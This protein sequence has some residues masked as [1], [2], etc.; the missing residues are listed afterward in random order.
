MY[1]GFSLWNRSFVY[2][3]FSSAWRDILSVEVSF[4]CVYD[5]FLWRN[6]SL[7]YERDFLSVWRGFFSSVKD[8][9]VHA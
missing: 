7:V 4:F 3:K 8:Y 1:V 9:F 2:E 6:R 5:G